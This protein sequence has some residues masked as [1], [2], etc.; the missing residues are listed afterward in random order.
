[1]L[2]GDPECRGIQTWNM[3]LLTFPCWNMKPIISFPFRGPKKPTNQ[4]TRQGALSWCKCRHRP[5]AKGV[6]ENTPL[7]KQKIPSIRNE[8]TW[9]PPVFSGSLENHRLKSD[10]L[11][12]YDILV[13]WRVL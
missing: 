1:M 2:G 11:M 4:P 3:K 5:L 9:D 10:F 7:K 6:S 13:S 12:G 8:K